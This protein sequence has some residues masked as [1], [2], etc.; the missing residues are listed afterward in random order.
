MEVDHMPPV[1]RS[2]GR[3][4]PPRPDRHV[5]EHLVGV[6]EEVPMHLPKGFQGGLV[7]GEGTRQIR[8]KG[9]R[10]NGTPHVCSTEDVLLR[11]SKDIL[12]RG[13]CTHGRHDDVLHVGQVHIGRV[14]VVAPWKSKR[15]VT[16]VHRSDDGMGRIRARRDRN[17]N[18]TV[19]VSRRL[20]HEANHALDMRVSAP[21]KGL[22]VVL[23]RLVSCR[24]RHD[25]GRDRGGPVLGETEDQD[26]AV[27]VGE[28]KDV[29]GKLPA[30]LGTRFVRLGT[31]LVLDVGSLGSILIADQGQKLVP[32][33][34]LES[35]DTEK[36]AQTEVEH[37]VTSQGASNGPH[38]PPP[39]PPCLLSNPMKATSEPGRRS[40]DSP[41]VPI[42]V[43]L[44]MVDIALS[45]SRDG[46]AT[47]GAGRSSRPKD[48]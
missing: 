28:R 24:H 31:G 9:D 16:D 33:D 30:T 35:L 20:R 11:L 46:R 41:L 43:P 13:R 5:L 22:P 45:A 42:V 1:A 2:I 12:A 34:V 29:L 39:K 4:D 8:D 32:G 6:P 17:Q 18:D 21:N 3:D 44:R 40:I 7:D 25:P 27:R 36:R 47:G 48:S 26:T 23:A 15:T 38:D 37:R 19:P 10:K 14:V